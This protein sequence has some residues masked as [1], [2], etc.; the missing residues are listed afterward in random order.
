MGTNKSVYVE[1]TA[2]ILLIIYATPT[3]ENLHY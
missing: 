1:I 3:L 2:V